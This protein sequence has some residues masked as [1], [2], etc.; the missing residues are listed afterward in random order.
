[1]SISALSTTFLHQRLPG[2]RGRLFVGGFLQ[3]LFQIVLVFFQRFKLADVGGELVVKFRKLLMRDRVDLHV[4]YGVLAFEL[5]CVVFGGEGD[6]DILFLA[7][8]HADELL[9]KA[10][11]KGLGA[12]DELLAFGRAAV[13]FHAVYRAGVIQVHFIAINY[14]ARSVISIERAICFCS[15]FRRA[16]SSSLVTVCRVRVISTPL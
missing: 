13:E 12:D 7:D 4:E 5:F 15:C 3:L 2:L 10:R 11:D 8:V 9:F 16:S 6:V 14:T 1:M